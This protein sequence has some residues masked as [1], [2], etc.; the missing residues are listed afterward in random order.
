MALF[1]H[2]PVFD[3]LN[4]EPR[5]AERLKVDQPGWPQDPPRQRGRPELGSLARN[6]PLFPGSLVFVGC[7]PL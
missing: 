2:P 7:V 3:Q 6:S 1:S 5:V 4:L